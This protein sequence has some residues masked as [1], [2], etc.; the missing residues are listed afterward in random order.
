M[1]SIYNQI[2]LIIL[3]TA[4]AACSGSSGRKAYYNDDIPTKVSKSIN[5]LNNVVIDAIRSD[6]AA[7]ISSILSENLRKN[8]TQERID[9]NINYVN[10]LI[11]GKT[12]KF[13]DQIYIP[14]TKAMN[15]DSIGAGFGEDRY[16]IYYEPYNTEVFVSLLYPDHSYDEFLI[17]LIYSKYSSGWKLDVIKFGVYKVLSK[18]AVDYYKESVEFYSKRH[19]IDASNALNVMWQCQRPAGQYFRY[20]LDDEMVNMLNY[21]TNELQFTYEFP[22]AVDT[23]EN[24]ARIFNVYPHRVSGLYYPM[25]QYITHVKL[26]DFA[27]LEEENKLIQQRIESFFPGITKNNETIYYRAYNE[28]PQGNKRVM[29]YGFLQAIKN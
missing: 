24:S 17:T 27:G 19:L 14:N 3:L 4:L 26:Y 28:V 20:K 21:I 12:F 25:I 23:I 16:Y 8:M 6:N 13:L 15:Y 18:N 10:N 1:R 22:M 29:H 7:L 2:Y 11:G 9:S 5:P